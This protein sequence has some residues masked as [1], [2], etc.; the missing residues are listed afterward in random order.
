MTLGKAAITAAC[1]SIASAGAAMAQSGTD[2]PEKCFDKG[3]LTY[4]DCPTEAD[5]PVAVETPDPEPRF[6]GFY[7]GAHAGV[8]VAEFDALYDNTPPQSSVNGLLDLRGPLAGLHAGY[9]HQFENDVV[10]G[11]EFDFSYIFDADDSESAPF[12]DT[13]IVTANL[14]YVATARLKLGYALG[15]VMPFVSGGAA[16]I[17]Y[18]ADVVDSGGGPFQKFEEDVFAAVI[19]GGFE[20]LVSD[21][22]LGRIQGDY[23]FLDEEHPFTIPPD[24]SPPDAVNANGMWS[25]RAGV[26]YKF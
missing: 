7:I 8:V 17:G 6:T 23:F 22:I 1:V 11:A 15:D 4:V 20:F 25:V 21:N 13:E 5:E 9:N 16:L 14:H 26:S 18:E 2:A 24:A 3:S 12:G 19:G 10:L